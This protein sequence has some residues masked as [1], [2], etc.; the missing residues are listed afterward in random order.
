MA[1]FPCSSSGFSPLFHLLDDYDVHRS[2]SPK[3]RVRPVRSFSPRFDVYEQDGSYHLDGELPGV[4]QN[5]IDIEFTD[6]HTLVIKGQVERQYNDTASDANESVDE[7]ADDT[8]SNKSLQPTVEDEDELNSSATPES[9]ASTSHPA[10]APSK[11]G[12]TYKYWASERSIGQF[13]RTFSFPT[14]VDQETVRASLRN[15][16]LSVIVPK[17]P[18][19]KLKKIRVE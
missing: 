12:S 3:S 10:A 5:N 11:P 7:P 14:R 4:D 1:F 8:S 6:P 13:Q 9:T 16:I 19:P 15:G 18:A 17:E 2:R